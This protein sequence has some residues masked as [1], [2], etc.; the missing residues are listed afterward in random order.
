L[1]HI[2]VLYG[3][4][5]GQT[6]KV[7][8]AID[9]ALI[10]HGCD[11]DVIAAGTLEPSPSDYDGIIVAASVHGGRFQPAVARW[12]AAH[13]SELNAKPTALV[14][15]CLGVLRHDDQARAELDAILHRFTDPP[16]WRPTIIKPVAGA[17]L[18]TH[19]DVVTRWFM[20]RIAAKTGGD[21]DTSRDHVYT[22]WEDVRAFATAFAGVVANPSDV[23]RDSP[24]PIDVLQGAQTNLTAR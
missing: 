16:G 24:P 4:T 13:A 23:S 5:H 12:V 7:V 17:L 18:Y 6:E 20:R 11:V 9:N 14:A 1:L 2:L 21:T 19:Y 8:T 10:D 3:T 15:V 22:D